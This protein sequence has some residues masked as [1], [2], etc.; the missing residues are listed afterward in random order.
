MFFDINAAIRTPEVESR[1]WIENV[2]QEVELCR[3]R[4]L[5][6]TETSLGFKAPLLNL[7]VLKGIRYGMV[8][9]ESGDGMSIL[10]YRLSLAPTRYALALFILGALVGTVNEGLS[11]ATVCRLLVGVVFGS[12]LYFVN[13]VGTSFAFG[14]LVRRTA[15]RATKATSRARCQPPPTSASP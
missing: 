7:G 9:A 1:T 15:A 4:T 13:V 6:K 2:A 8:S 10:H 3:G 5:A 12:L 14:R 11:I